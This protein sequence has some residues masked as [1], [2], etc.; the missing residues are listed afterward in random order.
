MKK[1]QFESLCHK[2][3]PALPGFECKSWLLL[4]PPNHLLRGF[5]C[6][7]SG[8]DRTKFT[9]YMF[10]LPLYVPTSHLYFL[11]GHRL[12]DDRGCEIWWDL[13]NAK[14]AED[15]LAR[16]QAQGMP[17]LNRIDSP[18]RLLEIARELPATQEGRKWETVA[19]SLLMLDDYAGARD[20]LDHLLAALD[21][22]IPW[23]AEMMERAL[24]LKQELSSDG[25]RA[26]RLLE[27][28]E[29]VSMENLGLL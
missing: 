2:I 27:Q 12:K 18:A 29:Q 3:L 6:D 10:V 8:F 11:F 17:F 22:A 19:Y 1:K 28:W 16:V 7:G 4:M 15:L 13:N 14:C 24:H 20:G 9:V 26:K 21:T 25:R 23:Q 5:C